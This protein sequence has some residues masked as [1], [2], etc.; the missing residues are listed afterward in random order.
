MS[1]CK[2]NQDQIKAAIHKAANSYDPP[3]DLKQRI[4]AQLAW[5]ENKE[6]I[7][8]KKFSTKKIVAAAAV[9]CTLTGTV[10]M[11][12][13]K[14][15]YYVGSSSPLTEITEYS[16]L[17]KVESTADIITGAPKAFDNGFV[18]ANANII[19]KNGMDNADNVVESFTEVNVNYK[20]G[21][22]QLDYMVQKGVTNDTDK[23]LE[24]KQ[25]I[26]SDGITYYYSRTNYLFLPAE[27]KPT[28]EELEAEEAGELF[29]SYG[30]SE[31]EEKVYTGISWNDDA[32]YHNI[33]SMDVEMDAEEMLAMAKQIQ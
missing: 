16:D 8:M 26:E 20:K 4:D 9:A 12:A 25:A 31:R 17:A 21:A 23:E 10:C 18:F 32:K 29:I 30:S 33:F 27:A 7:P 14:I 6:V 1:G 11:A 5:Q 2:T 28:A 22:D 24:R 13:G 19:N 15:S 3:M